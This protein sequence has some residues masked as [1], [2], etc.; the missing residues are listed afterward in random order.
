MYIY[1]CIMDACMCLW[2]VQ[3]SI[4][5]HLG[6]FNSCLFPTKGHAIS[7]WN[8]GVLA[9]KWFPLFR[10]GKSMRRSLA[11]TRHDLAFSESQLENPTGLSQQHVLYNKVHL[12][13]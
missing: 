5:R 4:L 7:K 9:K 1:I 12:K 8:F 11:R 6:Y 3:A 13:L 2:H 10:S